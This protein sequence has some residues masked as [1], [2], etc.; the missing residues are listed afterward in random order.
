VAGVSS[1]LSFTPSNPTS[2]NN[3]LLE[4]LTVAQLANKYPN[5]YGTRRFNTVEITVSWDVKPRLLL[6][7]CVVLRRCHY[8]DYIASNGRIIY[9]LYRA[10]HKA[11]PETPTII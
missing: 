4:K 7:R 5:I 2:N 3:K 10:V 6:R 1:G 11:P 9:G 8:L